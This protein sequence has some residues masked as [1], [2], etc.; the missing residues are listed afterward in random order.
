[1][2]KAKVGKVSNNEPQRKFLK[3]QLPTFD[4]GDDHDR[5]LL[6]KCCCDLVMIINL[7]NSRDG[8]FCTHFKS[9]TLGFLVHSGIF[10]SS[11]S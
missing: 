7:G 2:W 8:S 6:M 11:K 10:I 3:V 1:M 4:M 5:R 9:A